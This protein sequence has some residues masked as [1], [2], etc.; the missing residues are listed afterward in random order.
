MGY[1]FFEVIGIWWHGR[2]QAV[3]LAIPLIKPGREGNK[4]P[5]WFRAYY[6]AWVWSSYL[7]SD[8][9]PTEQWLYY[10]DEAARRLFQSWLED[11]KGRAV[12]DSLYWVAGWTGKPKHGYYTLEQW[13]DAVWTRAVWTIPG[14]IDDLAAEIATAHDNLQAWARSRY[15]AAI[16]KVTPLWT[17]VNITGSRLSAFYDDTHIWI[18]NFKANPAGTILGVLGSTWDNVKVFDQGALSYYFNLWGAYRETLADL[19]ADPL[20]FLYDRAEQYLVNKW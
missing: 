16:A 4:A 1:S 5:A 14:W 15:D 20:G 8:K 13:I 12:S 3:L 9:R 11:L 17:W 6:P 10:Y 7:D 18:A 2:W 19:I